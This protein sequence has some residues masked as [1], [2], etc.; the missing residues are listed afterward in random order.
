MPARF[1]LVAAL[2]PCPCGRSGMPRAACRCTPGEV[3]GYLGRLSGPLLD[4]IDLH[5][6]VPAPAFDEIA[7]PPGEGSSAVRHRVV[8]ARGRQARRADPNNPFVSNALLGPSQ[9]RAM[10]LPGSGEIDLSA[11]DALRAAVEGFCAANRLTFHAISAVT[12]EGLPTLVHEMARR[13]ASEQWMP[14]H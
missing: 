3:R 1:Q 5:V 12:G 11:N 6:A 9:V 13:L 7:A 8:A 10:L 2:N 14:A 4:R